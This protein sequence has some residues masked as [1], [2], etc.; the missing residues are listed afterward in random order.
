MNLHLSMNSLL[1]SLRY[2]NV[3]HFD[4]CYHGWYFLA[5]PF[6]VKSTL[7]VQNNLVIDIIS[8][9]LSL[10]SFSLAAG[11][12]GD[13][14]PLWPRQGPGIYLVYPGMLREVHV[15]FYFILQPK[16][17]RVHEDAAGNIY[18]AG[19]TDIK[20]ESENEVDMCMYMCTPHCS[21]NVCSISNGW[22]ELFTSLLHSCLTKLNKLMALASRWCSK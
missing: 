10:T 16:K 11:Q 7:C 1:S 17:L 21:G 9:S 6:C 15:S 14:W 12:W 4:C 8:F 19:A 18:V 2:S 20:V 3:L 5:F 22:L 13:H